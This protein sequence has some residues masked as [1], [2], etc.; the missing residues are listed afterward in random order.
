MIQKEGK[1]VLS[2]SSSPNL[3]TEAKEC[4]AAQEEKEF[5]SHSLFSQS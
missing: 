4:E 2:S 5:S 1:D 3:T